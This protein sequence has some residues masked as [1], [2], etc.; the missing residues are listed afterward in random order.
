MALSPI[1]KGPFKRLPSNLIVMKI[2]LQDFRSELNYFLRRLMSDKLYVLIWRE[3][4]L[5]DNEYGS[6]N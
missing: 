6:L 4:V 2:L 3:E 5:C 1:T